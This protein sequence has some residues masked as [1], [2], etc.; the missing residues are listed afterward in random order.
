MLASAPFPCVPRLRALPTLAAALLVACVPRADEDVVRRGDQA[1]ARD[2]VEEALAEYRLAVRQGREDAEVLA[3]A[4]HAYV[5]LG[6]VDEA[7]EFYARAASDEERWADLGSAD[8]VRVARDAASR[9]DRFLMASAMEA[10]RRLL[11]GLSVPDLTLPLARHYFQ[12]GEYGRAL[13]LY[14]RALAETGDSV[15]DV[16]FETGQAH[17]QIGDCR[18]ALVFFERFQ[19]LARPDA[20]SEV[21]WY[22]GNCSLRLAREL[23]DLGGE[24]DLD[25]ALRNVTRAIE[26]GE[27]RNL[28]GQAWFERGEVLAALGDCDAALDS[29]SQVQNLEPTGSTLARRA[30]QRFD[31]IRFGRALRDLRGRCG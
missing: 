20:L 3:R 8:L 6:R 12:N 27:P 1:F 22:L 31:D 24:A 15:P 29:F 7:S 14:Q 5:V 2:S 17:E 26:V 28:Q 10:A 18:S 13:P 25:E 21:N 30:Q 4:G 23:R 11:P 16:I 19:Q 9:N